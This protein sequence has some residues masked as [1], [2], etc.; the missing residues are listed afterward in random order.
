[1]RFFAI[2]LYFYSK[3]IRGTWMLNGG[4]ESVRSLAGWA[5][6]LPPPR[7]VEEK[8]KRHKTHVVELRNNRSRRCVVVPFKISFIKSWRTSGL[9]ADHNNTNRAHI[10]S[11]LRRPSQVLVW[12]FVGGVVVVVPFFDLTTRLL[13]ATVG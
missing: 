9:Q 7:R 3:A 6:S 5:S 11:Q 10:I 1:M 13:I 4:E 2:L 8:T 12:A